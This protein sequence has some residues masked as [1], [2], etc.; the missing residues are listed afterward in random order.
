MVSITLA[1]N[2]DRRTC[3]A[4]RSSSSRDFRL[5]SSIIVSIIPVTAPI[6]CS[7]A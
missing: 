7:R 1:T 6:C 4:F 2:A 3:S 5:T